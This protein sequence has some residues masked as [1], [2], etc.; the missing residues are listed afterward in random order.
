VRTAV[1]AGALGLIVCSHGVA[2]RDQRAPQTH[3][4][5]IADMRFQPEKLTV[6]SGDTVVWVNRDLVPH[7][8]TSEA[9]GFDSKAIPA[10]K[11]WRYTV[12]T[13]GNIVYLCTFHPSMKATL[14]VK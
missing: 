13:K 4:V 9:G 12:R 6:A 3:T 11:S 7:T 14:R 5:S 2:S 10:D 8:A 1:I